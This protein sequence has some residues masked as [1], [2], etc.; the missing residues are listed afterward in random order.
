MDV[1]CSKCGTRSTIPD[2][3]IPV[4]KSFM[5]CPICEARINIFKSFPVGAIVQ[6]L[7]GLRFMRQEGELCEEHCEP[8][9]LWRVV[10][11][12]SP[13]PDRGRGRSCEL[14][15]KGR[16]PNQRLILRLR[17]DKVLYKTCLYRKG[18]R[19]FDSAQRTAVGQTAPSSEVYPEG[20]DTYRVR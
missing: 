19:I 20:D 4:G 8:G 3:E 7:A 16:C 17:R 18:R 9:E 1:T 10:D 15:N 6:N 13:C 11:V 5:V 12:F 2:S 14:E